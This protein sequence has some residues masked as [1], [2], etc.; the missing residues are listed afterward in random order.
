[1]TSPHPL[2]PLPY[3]TGTG[4]SAT[5]QS[6]GVA[7]QGSEDEGGGGTFG[8]LYACLSISI[9][10]FLYQ[11]L[12]RYLRVYIYLYPTSYFSLYLYIHEHVSV[13]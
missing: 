10:L 5:K 7:L 6:R 12:F 2:T 9:C 13:Y 4:H 8:C 11:N 3:A 1:M